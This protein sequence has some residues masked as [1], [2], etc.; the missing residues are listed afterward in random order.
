MAHS[1]D[2]QQMKSSMSRLAVTIKLSSVSE[3]TKARSAPS[4]AA[5]FLPPTLFFRIHERPLSERLAVTNELSSAREFTKA[6]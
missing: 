2:E 4:E 5:S 3:F 1:S 6:R